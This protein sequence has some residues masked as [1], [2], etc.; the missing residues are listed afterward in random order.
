VDD[1]AASR[2]AAIAAPLR[3]PESM[4]LMLADRRPGAY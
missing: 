3:R 1:E 2:T 4:Q